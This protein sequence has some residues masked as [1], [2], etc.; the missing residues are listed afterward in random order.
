[1]DDPVRIGPRVL[2][3][4]PGIFAKAISGLFYFSRGK[5]DAC[6]EALSSRRIHLQPKQTGLGLVLFFFF[7]INTSE[8]FN[9]NSSISLHKSPWIT[10]KTYKHDPPIIRHGTHF[11]VFV[12]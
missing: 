6:L 11:G 5:F 12:P 2:N 3:P 1:M 9:A 10:L 4:D 7:F 8:I